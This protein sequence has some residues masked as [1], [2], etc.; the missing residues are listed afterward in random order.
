MRKGNSK[1]EHKF[2]QKF[3]TTWDKALERIEFIK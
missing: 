1:M 2:V 3:I